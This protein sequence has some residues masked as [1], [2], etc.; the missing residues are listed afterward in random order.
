MARV[1]RNP[2]ETQRKI[3]EAALEEFLV[4][5][6][7]GARVDNIVNRAGVN[8]RMVYHYFGDKKGLFKAVLDQ[9]YDAI[10]QFAKDTPADN[11]FESINY[12][13]DSKVLGRN[14]FKLSRQLDVLSEEERA[15]YDDRQRQSFAI[16]AQLFKTLQD[17]GL[18]SDQVDPSFLLMGMI[19]LVSMPLMEPDFVRNITGVDSESPEFKEKYQDVLKALVGG[20]KSS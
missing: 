1:G 5:N 15:I 10:E 12:W 7:H 4:N 17:K 6:F 2:Q 14:Y 18:I 8:K 3:L 11:L 20:L 9:E 19:S 13:L 16:Q